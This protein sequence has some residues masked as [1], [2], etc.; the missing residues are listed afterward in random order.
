MSI[1]QRPCK[2]CLHYDAIVR[3]DNRPTQRGWCADKSEYPAVEPDGKLSPDGVRRVAPGEL[4]RPFIVV[5][6]EVVSHCT[7]FR[8]KGA[9]RS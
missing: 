7:A 1:N 6:T 5:G 8:E 9:P 4:A 2:D 3:G